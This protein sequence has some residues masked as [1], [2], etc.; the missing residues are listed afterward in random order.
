LR[1]AG[2][3]SILRGGVLR[4]MRR[5][6]TALC[7]AGVL[8]LLG[9]ASASAFGPVGSFDGSGGSSGPFS[10]PQGAV[11]TGATV[12]VADTGNSRV[13][14]FDPAGTFQNNLASPPSGPQDVAANGAL[15][16]AAGPSQVV[17]WL[18]GLP[19]PTIN[20]PGTS[21]GVAIVGG[22]I[23][24]SD[25][26]AGVIH[27]YDS[28]LGTFQGDIGAGQLVQPQG[29]TAAGGAIYVADP[30][31]GRIAK[32]DP[33]GNL[34][35][36]FPMPSYTIVAGGQTITGRIEPH[37]VAVDASGRVFVPD[38]GTQSNLLAI[39]GPGGDLQQIIGSPVSDPGNPCRLSGPW[40][41]AVSGSLLYVVSTGDNRVAIF[42]DAAPPCPVVN[43]GPGGG[44]NPLPTG[45]IANPTASDRRRPKIKLK[46]IPKGCAR[47]NFAFRIRASD[48]V[49][50]KRLILLVNRRR[51]AN[52][53][54]QGQRW[55][56]R[57]KIP[58]RRVSR[59]LPRGA[60]VPV[61]IEVRVKDATGKKARIR[62]A[63]EICG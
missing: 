18:A 3:L 63:F 25:A 46:G 2:R 16:V 60:S 43:F 27:K 21:Y 14:F 6:A 15:V 5:I 9:P 31:A 29:M 13:P 36:T 19:L 34:G 38:A 53:A 23:F 48:D 4:E 22:T 54:I 30:G 28:T 51:V 59:S 26:A 37:D 35:G 12:Y 11:A 10:H 57:V 61:L 7:A 32:F 20:P 41:V 45:G 56:V 40:G 33:A 62:R 52:E 42:D 1:A 44:I 50:L 58:A 17:R 47:R 49:L 39:F 55:N 8:A 24:V